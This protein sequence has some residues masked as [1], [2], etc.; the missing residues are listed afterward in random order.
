MLK[1]KSIQTY[2]TYRKQEINML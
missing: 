1:N 2:S